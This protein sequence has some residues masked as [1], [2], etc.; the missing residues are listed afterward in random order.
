MIRLLIVEDHAAIAEALGALLGTGHEVHVHG[1]VRDAATAEARLGS[2]PPDV[3]LCDVMLGGS[4]RGFDLLRR[5]GSDAAFVMYSAFEFPAHHARALELGAKGYVSKTAPV[6]E[7]VA[8]IRR[9][10]A[11]QRAFPRQVL[12]SARAAPAPP[13]AR[14]LQVI[15]MVAAGA[16]NEQLA[17]QLGLRV[18]SVEGTLRR[19]FDRYGVRNRT[20][21]VALANR[22]GWLMPVQDPTGSPG[23]AGRSG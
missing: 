19:L 4:D 10:A 18:K 17:E 16:T 12:D 8:V 7:I 5:F 9:A 23:V 20:Q 11:G 15:A 2:D 6:D 13:T 21:L 14:E 22:Q 1:V 3:V